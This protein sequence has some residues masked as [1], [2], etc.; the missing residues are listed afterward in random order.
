[1][2]LPLHEYLLHDI[3]PPE[4]VSF[5]KYPSYSFITVNVSVLHPFILNEQVNWVDRRFIAVGHP[6]IHRN[7]VQNRVKYQKV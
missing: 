3:I 2:L 5:I 4:R 7:R 6:D 1:M